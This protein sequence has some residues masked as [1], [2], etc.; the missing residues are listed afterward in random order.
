MSVK[1]VKLENFANELKDFTEKTLQQQKAAVTSGL[2]RSIPDLVAASPVDTGLY[3]QSWN[4]TVDEQTGGLNQILISNRNIVSHKN[5]YHIFEPVYVTGTSSPVY[6]KIKNVNIVENNETS[7][8][9]KT[10]VILELNTFNNFS[11][12]YNLNKLN[13]T[14]TCRIQFEKSQVKEKESLHF[15]FPFAAEIADIIYNSGKE[16][17]SVSHDQLSGSNKDFICTEGELKLLSNDYRISISSPLF[18][19]FELNN[20]IDETPVNGSKKWKTTMGDLST[21]YLYVLNNYW[22]TN[23]KAWQNGVFDFTVTISADDN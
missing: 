22:H 9:K 23:F 13:G 20:I 6:S 11:I 14:L 7:E 2:A 8:L 10:K 12:T 4:F 3:A 17:I 21:V 16:F 18:N 5:P 19:I 15:A 1:V